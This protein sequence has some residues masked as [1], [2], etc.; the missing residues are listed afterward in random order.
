MLLVVVCCWNLESHFYLL[1]S[2]FHFCSF[3]PIGTPC[4]NCVPGLYRNGGAVDKVNCK[5]CPAGYY[6][7]SNASASCLP[8]IPGFYEDSETSI[9]CKEC[10]V[11]TYQDE[12][13]QISCKPCGTGRSVANNASASCE[14][15]AAG[16]AGMY[17]LLVVVVVGC[18]WLLLVVVGCCWLLLVAVFRKIKIVLTHFFMNFFFIFFCFLGGV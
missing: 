11:D 5:S 14:A 18:C 2:I 6:Q 4:T 15:C 10:L 16:K 12:T 13:T 3:F 17:L 9:G 7:L 1:L 8:C